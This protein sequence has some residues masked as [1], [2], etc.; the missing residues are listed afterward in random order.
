MNEYGFSIGGPIWKNKIFLFGNYMGFR[1][2]ALTKP[3]AQNIPTPAEL[4]GDFSVAD[5]GNT[6]SIYDPTSQTLAA[7]AIR[8]RSSAPPLPPSPPPTA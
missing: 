2:S 5:T 1:F 7:R 6:Q 8:A 4:C 3:Q